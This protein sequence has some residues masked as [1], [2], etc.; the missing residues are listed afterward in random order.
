MAEAA[1]PQP[2]RTISRESCAVSTRET[3]GAFADF[4]SD[5]SS[6]EDEDDA[7]SRALLRMQQQAD[8]SMY[9][10]VPFKLKDSNDSSFRLTMKKPEDYEV[11]GPAKLMDIEVLKPQIK[12]VKEFVTVEDVMDLVSMVERATSS[13]A[14][15]YFDD[16]NS[17][18][19]ETTEPKR[20]TSVRETESAFADFLSDGSNSSEEEDEDDADTRKLLRMQQQADD[21][22]FVEMKLD[23]ER[24]GS[25]SGNSF[26][27]T[28]AK[29]G[30]FDDEFNGPRKL[31]EEAKRRESAAQPRESEDEEETEEHA[32][33]SF[34]DVNSFSGD[35]F[36]EPVAVQK[37]SL[38]SRPPS[39]DD[40][41]DSF[42]NEPRP[43]FSDEHSFTGGGDSF[44]DSSFVYRPSLPDDEEI[45]SKTQDNANRFVDVSFVYRPSLQA[46]D[47]EKEVKDLAQPEGDSSPALA[48]CG[49]EIM[50][51]VQPESDSG[52]ALPQEVPDTE[53]DEQ[54][55]AV[56][57]SSQ[58]P[59]PDDSET[60]SSETT[61]STTAKDSSFV[62]R[63][64]LD[65]DV[66]EIV[67]DYT[68]PASA[69]A[70][71]ETSFVYRVTLPG[72]DDEVQGAVATE[73]QEENSALSTGKESPR[74]SDEQEPS[75][76]SPTASSFIRSSDA[77]AFN[78]EAADSS[79]RLNEET[80]E[81]NSL[82]V[83]TPPT[84]DTLGLVKGVEVTPK[85]TTDVIPSLSRQSSAASTGSAQDFA[86]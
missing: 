62:Y 21:Q 55:S 10:E 57:P 53:V 63:P 64:T 49:G 52:Q 22:M 74:A 50:D 80:E 82:C 83:L 35:S 61:G 7:D 30:E 78:F 19:T 4:L 38:A 76:L 28:L 67:F 54:S 39:F 73:I 3:E 75:F 34:S 66:P 32:D 25:G 36:V 84:A 20:K 77:V 13:T 46:N 41:G 85:T 27:L 69:A 12:D 81:G 43:S 16:I 71:E 47:K 45:P 14:E 51:P 18:S 31:V 8:D 6:D 86:S 17:S 59:L 5:G 1:A 29:P 15:G 79:F 48:D 23:D 26:R 37:E 65:E 42:F 68:R 56:D 58:P 2:R 72:T 60:I 44:I 70:E 24:K 9:S 40:E 11:A 33:P